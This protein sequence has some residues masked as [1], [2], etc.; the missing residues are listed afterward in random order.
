MDHEWSNF[1]AVA[2]RKFLHIRGTPFAIAKA[3]Y[4]LAVGLEAHVY[5][6]YHKRAAE[7]YPS[8]QNSPIPIS[9]TGV[10]SD[11][12][13]LGVYFQKFQQRLVLTI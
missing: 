13:R 11:S 10:N 2:G 7:S 4:G 1:C 8:E 3:E 5:R 6:Q 9:A 12:H